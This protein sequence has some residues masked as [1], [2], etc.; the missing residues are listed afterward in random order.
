MCAVRFSDAFR[1]PQA[2]F[3]FF[4]GLPEVT[5]KTKQNLAA[6]EDKQKSSSY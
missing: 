4:F 6:L 1:F 5:L 3:T 2:N